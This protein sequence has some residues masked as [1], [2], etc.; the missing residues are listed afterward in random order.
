MSIN[1]INIVMKMFVFSAL[2]QKYDHSQSSTYK[3]DGR[4]FNI[5]KVLSG[6]MS[7][8]VFSVSNLS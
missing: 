4:A 8:D 1:K 2:H 3:K 5:S 7:T 6:Y